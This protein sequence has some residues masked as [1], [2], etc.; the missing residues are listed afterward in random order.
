[1]IRPGRQLQSRIDLA[2]Q[3]GPVWSHHLRLI[4]LF[5]DAK[6]LAIGPSLPAGNGGVSISLVG[7]LVKEP[8][9]GVMA[10]VVLLLGSFQQLAGTVVRLG[11]RAACLE[12]VVV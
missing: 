10:V 3:L 12:R 5:D 9:F 6:E 1:T 7:L 8:R 11:Q 2:L 4:E